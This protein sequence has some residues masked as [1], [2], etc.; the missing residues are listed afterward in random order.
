[1]VSK[2]L[3]LEHILRPSSLTD[4][5]A[6]AII[7]LHGY[8]SNEQDL[9]SFAP[10]MDEEYLIVSAKAPIPMRPY[11]NAWYEI[12]YSPGNEKF[13]NGEQA[14]LS[15]D[16][17]AKFVDEVAEAY[18]ADPQQITLMGFSQGAILSY[19]VALSYPEK[20]NRV[21]AMSGYIHDTLLKENYRTNDFSKLS[22]YVS[23][24]WA[25]E[26]V[27]VQWDRL[28]KPFLEELGIPV[29]YSEFPVGHGVS[30]DNFK[31]ILE[32]LAQ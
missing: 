8:G 21:V 22:F 29:K 7:L 3:S 10:E 31:E 30:P 16:L 27:P 4:Q 1:M 5:K 24:G 15:R 25:D 6:P 14:V 28:T 26:V 13:T 20:I 32:W 23:H 17:I 18:Y 9:F 19:A 12:T 2:N 11:G